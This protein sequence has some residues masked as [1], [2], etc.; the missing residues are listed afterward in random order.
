MKTIRTIL[1]TVALVALA[2]VAF[3]QNVGI[4]SDGS[5]PASSAMLDV[6]STTKG[7]LA[8][9]MTAAQ[10]AAIVSPAT[11]LLIYQT[12]GTE[13]YYYNSGTSASPTW[14]QLGAASGASQWATAGSDI[15][16]N[17]GNVGIGTTTPADLLQVGNIMIGGNFGREIYSTTGYHINYKATGGSAHHFFTNGTE[18]LNIQSNGNVGIGTETPVAKLHVEGG[19]A[20]IA[21]TESPYLDFYH[22]NG[23]TDLKD[24]RIGCNNGVMTFESVNDA[25]TTSVERMR[26]DAIGNVGIGT[27]TPQSRLEVAGRM[28]INY[29]ASPGFYGQV[30]GVDKVYLGYDGAGTGLQLYNFTSTKSLM[31][32]DNGALVYSGNVGLGTDAP[33][34]NL[35]VNGATNCH[36]ELQ[37]AGVAK[38]YIWWDNV[39]NGGVLG[40]GTGNTGSSIIF[41]D[42]KIGVGTT[43]PAYLLTING[44]AYCNG[45]T[46]TNASDARLKRDIQPMS[47]YGLSTV[48][49][50]KPV[51]YFY[52]ADKT[53][54]P[55][56]GFIAQD[57]Q[58]IVPEVVSGTE[59]DIS[60]GET[61]G[62]SYGNLVPVLTK[63]IQEQQAE[64]E[65]LKAE[66]ASMKA[67]NANLKAEN[68]SIKSDVEALKSA[69]YGTAQTR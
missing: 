26:I 41:K 8:P 31:I 64:I 67:D 46:W 10:K 1:I 69:V 28:A 21:Y 58:K 48:M 63:A 34:S 52:K 11:G 45:T 33:T 44:G 51:M 38:G 53:N 24:T 35:T 56:V 12:D 30:A 18:K 43:S 62:L 32:Q 4:N 55:E 5:A 27:R 59:G 49:Q 42:G 61:L 66:N 57:M 65:A 54:H 7:F 14:T 39:T 37:S 16:Y 6:S 40:V 29:A 36:I 22:I 3:A 19:Y 17:T 15:Y 25:Y 23:G 68:T 9:Q 50:L 13:G 60:K 47:K 2:T 20:R